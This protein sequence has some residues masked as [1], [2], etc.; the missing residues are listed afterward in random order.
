MSAGRPWGL[1]TQSKLDVLSYYLR[2]F[3]VASSKRAR[4]TIYLDLFAGRDK[5]VDKY[6]NQP[7]KGSM[8]RALET[9]PA[10]SILRGF[11]LIR[12][13][14]SELEATYRSEFPGRDLVIYPGDVHDTLP[15]A[16]RELSAHRFAPTFAFV[17]PDG[18]EARW[19][20]LE[21]PAKFKH[22][23]SKTKVEI[24]FLFSTPS[25]ARIFHTK[26]DEYGLQHAAQQI[27]N[28]VGSTEW[29]PILRDRQID[30]LDPEQSRFE[31]I[32]LM[33]WRFEHVLG[34]GWT[35]PFRLQNVHGGPIYDMIFATDH[36]AG[37]RIM[38]DIY[39]SAAQRYSQQRYELRARLRDQ[40]E[41]DKGIGSLFSLEE[42]SAD[43][44]LKAHETYS[45]IPV[46]LPYGFDE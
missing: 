35:H 3:N 37:D 7:I 2:A 16:L 28:L 18:V 17:D 11:E 31:L 40:R 43:A 6:S 32:N 13:R 41:Q 24:F 34:Y 27:T 26:Q 8:R 1:W 33:R 38:R 10:F 22:P 4:G 20:L 42:L 39:R 5:N 14:A 15:V 12:R 30:I 36:E 29:M 44:P 21:A 23:V 9:E 45:W 25:L 46:E 19:E